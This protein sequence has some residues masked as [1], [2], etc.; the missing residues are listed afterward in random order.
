MT[1]I[2]LL[3]V[4]S[5]SLK[6]ALASEGSVYPGISWI[7]KK[8]QNLKQN[9][10]L[11]TYKN[12]FQTKYDSSEK[13]ELHK[14]TAKQIINKYINAIGGKKNLSK[15]KDRTTYLSGNVRSTK[16]RMTIYQKIPDK[17]KQVINTDSVVQ[18][19]YYENSKGEMIS[20]NQT[21][22]LKGP[23][24]EKLKYESTLQ[25]LLNLDSLGIKLKFD[26]VK[27]VDGIP[28][29][30]LD[31]IFPSG[32]KW[33]QYYDTTTGLKIQ[34]AKNVKTLQGAFAQLTEFADYKKIDGIKYP[35]SIK[36]MLGSQSMEFKVDS[37]KVNTGLEDSLFKI[38]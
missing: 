28:A 16:V 10:S 23:E 32:S 7:L 25:L 3:I 1:I 12:Y 37:I 31:M 30:V 18:A 20:A 2:F 19:I 36:Q 15:I 13:Q 8:D 34:E 6:P 22:E 38:K 9:T 24:L 14:I 17:L 4:F 29:Y 11:S 33:T 27:N 5:L 35:F 21:M 26:G